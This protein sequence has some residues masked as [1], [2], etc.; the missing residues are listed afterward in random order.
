MS[1]ERGDEP[2]RN[3]VLGG[4]HGDPRRER[5]D[6]LV[7]DVLVHELRGLPQR[8]H[9]D[10]GVEPE[11]GERGRQR[12]AGDP[13]DGQRDRIDRAGDEVGS[14]ARGLEARGHRVAAG[15]LTVEADRQAARLLERLDKLLRAV[16]LERAR[17]VVQQHARGAERRQLA[18]LLDQRLGFVRV[19]GAEHEP[20]VE[21]LA[22]ARDRLAGLAQVLDVVQRVVQ[23]EDFD[24]A[25][26]GR[27]DE[28][29][30]ELAADRARADEEPPAQRHRERRLGAL[31]Q[32]TDP[33]PRALDAAAH[34]RVEDSAARDLEVG[35]TGLVEDLRE[36]QQLRRRHQARERLLG[37]QADRGIDQCR[38]GPQPNASYAREM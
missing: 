15:A 13:V 38:H 12:L 31:V 32:R 36:A 22:G 9:V 6:G 26:G 10:A 19:A 4:A 11:P 25:L 8:G 20:C 28:A 18:R 14:G 21:L 16:R 37:Q 34:G 17:R 1:V 33:L 2:G 30:D 5:G 3:L 29:A 7:A 23:P 24:P 27:G 35:E